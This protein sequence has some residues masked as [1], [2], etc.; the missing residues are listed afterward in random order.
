MGLSIVVIDCAL[1]DISKFEQ[2]LRHFPAYFEKCYSEL[3]FNFF[4][5]SITHTV[6]AY[7]EICNVEQH[8]H[9]MHAYNISRSNISHSQTMR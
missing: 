3:T 4:P 7:M 8:R 5:F 6:L 1:C 2:Q 9:T